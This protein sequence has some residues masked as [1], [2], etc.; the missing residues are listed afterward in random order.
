VKLLREFCFGG[1]LF[2]HA[3]FLCLERSVPRSP[4][5]THYLV[6]RMGQ[7]TFVVACGALTLMLGFS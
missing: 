7:A 3:A 6:V 5:V 2:G 4:V 1:H